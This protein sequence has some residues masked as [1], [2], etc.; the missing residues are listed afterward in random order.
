VLSLPYF[1]LRHKSFAAAVILTG[2]ITQYLPWARITRVIFLYHMFG[3]LIFMILALAFVL[4]RMQDAG[5]LRIEF[6]GDRAVLSTRWLVPALL[7]L[8]VLFFLYF[9]P[10]WTALPI[11][12]LSYRS[13]FPLGKMW[14]PT[15][16]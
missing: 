10:V 9:Y 15:W 4:V 5:P 1:V 2:F 3:G 13:G 7:V 11:S 6:F 8:V 14:I 16:F 12:D